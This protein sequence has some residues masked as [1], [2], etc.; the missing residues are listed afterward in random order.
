[1]DIDNDQRL[2]LHIDDTFARKFADAT[3]G[4]GNFRNG[5]TGEIE[6]GNVIVTSCLQ[7]NGLYFPFL[8]VLYL[9]EDESER[10]DEPFKTKLEI[11]VEEII[12]PL[13][14]WS[15]THRCCRLSVLF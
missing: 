3:D 12:E 5:S 2:K 6:D 9:G 15:G 10:L 11:S 14:R 1:V 7:T 8:P 4:V 13:Q